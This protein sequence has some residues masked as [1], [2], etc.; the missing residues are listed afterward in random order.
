[1]DVIQILSSIG[2]AS[3]TF[4][5]LAA[6]F[7][8][9]RSSTAGDMHA[10]GRTTII[11]EGG[12]ILTLLSYTPAVLPALGLDPLVSWRECAALG[13]FFSARATYMAVTDTGRKG[14]T[15]LL[16]AVAMLLDITSLGSFAACI[17]APAS[18]PVAGIYLA[19]VVQTLAFVG[20]SFIGQFRA[21]RQIP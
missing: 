4:M 20:V 15:P 9:F 8:A 19:A 6:V 1:M 12:L 21:E 17:L 16:L 7:S 13:I 18:W 11:I 2:E 14:K 3:L 5:G 10:T